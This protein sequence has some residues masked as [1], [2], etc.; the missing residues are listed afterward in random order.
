[1]L[2]NR[3]LCW[4]IGLRICLPWLPFPSLSL[5]YVLPMF[6]SFD[7]GFVNQKKVFFEA[8]EAQLI[9]PRFWFLGYLP[10]RHSKFGVDYRHEVPFTS[11]HSLARVF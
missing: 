10:V 5:P 1:M 9:V 2:P 6:L 8:K 11:W 3:R 7:C 4:N